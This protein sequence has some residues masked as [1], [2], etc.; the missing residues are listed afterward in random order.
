MAVVIALA[1]AGPLHAQAQPD[2]RGTRGAATADSAAARQPAAPAWRPVRV[3]KWTTLAA[4]AGAASYGFASNRRAD[5]AYEDLERLCQQDRERCSARLPGGAYS[6]PALEAEYQ[7]I[8]GLDRRARVALI[9]GQVGVAASVAL[10]ILDLRN[11]RPPGNIPFD[12]DR[13]RLGANRD[14]GVTVGWRMPF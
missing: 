7:R 10:F 2:S 1:T 8:R 11:E 9:A 4:A 14:G 6:D 3:A 13:L 5:R 12:P